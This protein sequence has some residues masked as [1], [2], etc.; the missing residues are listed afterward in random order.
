M[1]RKTSRLRAMERARDQRP[2]VFRGA[3]LAIPMSLLL[4]WM[5]YEVVR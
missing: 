3:L 2:L 4:W 5:L 1:T